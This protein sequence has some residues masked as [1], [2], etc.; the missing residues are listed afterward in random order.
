MAEHGSCLTAVYAGNKRKSFCETCGLNAVDRAGHFEYTKLVLPGFHVGFFR[1]IINVLQCICKVH[2]H[3]TTPIYPP[4]YCKLQ[5]CARVMVDDASRSCFLRQFRH[6][7]LGNIA[8][9]SLCK[10]VLAQARK[11][12]FCDHCKAINGQ[13]RRV[14]H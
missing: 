14:D 6:L 1:H 4:S 10:Q 12:N 3:P 5:T 11:V 7:D 2:L 13:S 9:Q 8:R